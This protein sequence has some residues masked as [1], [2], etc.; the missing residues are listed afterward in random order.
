MIMLNIRRGNSDPALARATPP[1][2]AKP[3]PVQPRE[4]HPAAQ[5]AAAQYSAVWEENDILR[6][7]NQRL[8]NEVEVARNLDAEKTALLSN[9]RQQLDDA[10]RHG[11]ER[12]YQIEAHFRDRLAQAERSKERYLRYA[13]GIS[14]R[15]KVCADQIA[16]AHAG[17]MEM[18][19]TAPLDAAEQKIEAE[20]KELITAGTDKDK[21]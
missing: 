10:Q 8:K 1:V 20:V 15:L 11:D 19:N 7:E 17:A 3:T 21:T 6:A 14:E 2:P 12:V 4:L 5:A 18:A 9:L 16:E 13:V